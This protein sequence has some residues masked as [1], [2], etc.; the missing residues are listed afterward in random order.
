MQKSTIE[1]ISEFKPNYCVM[2]KKI[3]KDMY[4]ESLMLYA[5]NMLLDRIQDQEKNMLLD[6]SQ[7]QEK[8]NYKFINHDP[9]ISLSAIKNRYKDIVTNKK[10][11]TF[12]TYQLPENYGDLL[13]KVKETPIPS[14]CKK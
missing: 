13:K 11:I 10:N 6:G 7:D 9:A 12:P 1:S 5:E 3:R 4:W 2:M 14:I 8:K